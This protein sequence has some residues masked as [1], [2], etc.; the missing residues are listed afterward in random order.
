M[1]VSI[2]HA[3][4][5]VVG[6][7]T[8]GAGIAQVAAVAGRRVLITDAVPGAAER[9]V[10]GIRDR[11]KAQV[12]KGRLSVDPDALDLTAAAVSSSGMIL[13]TARA[14]AAMPGMP[15]QSVPKIIRFV[16]L[17]QFCLA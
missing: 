7:G 6:A 2:G 5:G 8:M 11:V 16:S 17:V 13:A 15:G 12:A 14:L 1:T 9:A 4:I 3:A 10:T